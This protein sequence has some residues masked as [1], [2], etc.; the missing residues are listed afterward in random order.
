MAGDDSEHGR[1]LTIVKAFSH[2]WGFYRT[3]A[4]VK[5][6]WAELVILP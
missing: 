6:V 1:G 5:M 3:S 4:Y 2:R